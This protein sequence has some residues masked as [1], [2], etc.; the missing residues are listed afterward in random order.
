MFCICNNNDW[1]VEIGTSLW[2]PGWLQRRQFDT[3]VAGKFDFS[4]RNFKVKLTDT[5]LDPIWSH[6]QIH[7]GDICCI[8][9]FR[10]LLCYAGSS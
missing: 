6:F 5:D 8:G 10:M 4:E 2:G 3:A 9:N 1:Q 7:R